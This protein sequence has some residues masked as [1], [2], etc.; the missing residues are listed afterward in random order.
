MRAFQC[1][2]PLAGQRAVQLCNAGGIVDCCINF[3]GI[4][5]EPHIENSQKISKDLPITDI[6]MNFKEQMITIAAVCH[7]RFTE[8]H[9]H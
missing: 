9:R 4:C 8:A 3:H 6:C 2:G 7:N 1:A 5:T